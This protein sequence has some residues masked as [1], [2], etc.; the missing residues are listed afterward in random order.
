MSSAHTIAERRREIGFIFG[1][2]PCAR[3]LMRDPGLDRSSPRKRGPRIEHWMPAFAGMS[4]IGSRVAAFLLA[5][6]LRRLLARLR[7]RIGEAHREPVG[8]PQVDRG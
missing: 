5:G 2:R 3:S 7:D 8:Q 1:A 6:F 4:G